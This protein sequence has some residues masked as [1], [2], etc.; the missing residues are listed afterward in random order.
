MS[1]DVKTKEEKRRVRTVFETAV[2]L[3]ILNISVSY[4]T[5]S[6]IV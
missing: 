6:P 3:N 1:M 5:Q 4:A 2:Y